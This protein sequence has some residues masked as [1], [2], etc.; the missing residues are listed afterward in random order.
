LGF[1]LVLSHSLGDADREAAV[2]RRLISRRVDGLFICPVY[3]METEA[4]AYEELQRS[5]LPTVILGHTA[6]F[7]A[8]FSSVSTDDTEAAAQVCRHLIAMGHRRIA[9]FSGP[10]VA[11]WAQERL[12]GYRIAL[13]DAGIPLND[14]WVFNAGATIAEGALAAEQFLRER[15][16]VTAI[17]SA[18]DLIAIGGANTL[19]EQ[20]VKIPEQLSIVGFG[21]VLTSQYF[22]VPLTTVRQP[23][24]RLGKVAMN[25]MQQLLQHEPPMNQRMPAEIIFRASIAPPCESVA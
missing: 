17:Q 13:R 12:E 24:L 3:R 1:D 16:N 23:K 4:P 20:G 18:N 8:G 6:P 14:Q 9:F 7:C 11:P 15:P 21:N 25:I 10:M 5:G 22:R 2:I 19:I